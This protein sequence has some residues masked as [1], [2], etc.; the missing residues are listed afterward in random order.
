MNFTDLEVYQ[1]SGELTVIIYKLTAKFP[2][3]ELFGLTSQIRRAVCSI[4]ANIAEG[5]GRFHYK[6]RLNF[7]FT[8]RGSLF[9]VKHFLLLSISLGFVKKEDLKTTFELI[10]TLSVKM[11]NYIKATRNLSKQ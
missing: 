10:D 4:G 6:D 5:F 1:L 2:K 8:A 11:N 3:D 9:E 7:L